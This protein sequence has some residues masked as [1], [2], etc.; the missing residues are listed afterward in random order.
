MLFIGC[1]ANKSVVGL[2]YDER[3]IFE[4][5]YFEGSKQKVL[6]NKEKALEQYKAALQVHPESH[7][8]MYEFA[9]LHY[10]LENYNEAL[11]WA[12]QAVNKSAKY[13]HFYHGQL[14]QF[15]NKF[16]K[17]EQ[18]ADVFLQMVENE[19]EVKENYIETANQYYNY[20]S[21]DKSIAI[22][23]KMQRKFGIEPSSSTRLEF[24]YSK[25]GK[26]DLAI[27]E[28]QKLSNKFPNSIEYLGYLSD[29]YM[30]DNQTT[31]AINVLEKIIQLDSNEGFAYFALF[32]IYSKIGEEQLAFKNLKQ[33]FHKDNLPIEQKLQAVSGYFLK[34]R[35]NG[36]NKRE[37]LELSDVLMEKYP[38]YKE[39][40]L[41]RANIYAT[42]NDFE[43]ARK[44]TKTALEID[45]SDFK[46]WSKLL[47]Y[48]NQLK[49]NKN[50]LKDVNNALELF[51]NFAGFY[52]IK[53]N[54]LYLLKRYKEAIET[55]DIG[56]D[57][58]IEKPDR[59]DLLLVKASSLNNLKEF[60]KADQLF[61]KILEMNPVSVWPLNNYAYNLAERNEKLSF[62]DSLISKAMKLESNSAHL[63]DTKAWVLFRLGKYADAAKW[64]EKAL[65]LK[66]NN[67]EFLKHLKEVYL[68]L[69][70][71][72]L[73]NDTQLKIDKL[74][75]E[76]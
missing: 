21:F 33:S 48:N 76:N 11:Y 7:A 37:V 44:Y 50:Q 8:T 22:L 69:K 51:P 4:K 34:L 32:N 17:Y 49:N 14:A 66:A 27:A 68:K 52:I 5:Y 65:E 1:R 63:M 47:A 42:T 53:A 62:A 3:K 70:N 26:K 24:V 73:A 16:G 35:N 46:S 64:L 2:D 28:M 74:L 67:I 12:K 25:M 60:K 31:N 15:Y 58:T 40:Y 61:D 75:S 43:N 19:P 71:T 38:T 29:A 23:K 10:Q 6:N 18:S 59:V 30:A 54:E 36:R 45:P 41:L 56:Y 55:A 72:T 20:K 39:P 9:R 13:N 57:L